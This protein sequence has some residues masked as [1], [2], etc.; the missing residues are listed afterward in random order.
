MDKLF[1]DTNIFESKGFNFDK[2]NILIKVLTN[3]IKANK[4]KYYNLSVIDN[5]IISH[6]K[7]KSGD[8]EKL[9][10]KQYKWIEKY[11]D[12]K[13]IHDNCFKNLIDYKKF[14]EDI[15]AVN[16]DVSKINAEKIFKKYFDIK[17]PFEVKEDKRKEFPDAFISEY[18][19]DLSKAE[20]DRVYFVSKDNG[21]KKS[22][23]ESITKYDSIEKFLIAINGI[24]PEDFLNI[25]N[26]IK[27]NLDEIGLRL[28]ENGDFKNIDL[29]EEIIE[30]ELIKLS[31]EF[32][33]EILDVNENEIYVSC[34]F[35]KLIISGDFRCLDYENSYWPNDEEYYVYTEYYGTNEIQ[36]DDYEMNLKIKKHNEDYIIEYDN[37]YPIEINFEKIK[38]YATEHF[39]PYDDY[40]GEDS[41]AQ[42]GG[43]R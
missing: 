43:S 16:C 42:D 8:E 15:G 23:D 29:E 12:E 26:Y 27:S 9:L 14:K 2:R 10:K 5:E 39:S 36:Y 28:L 40:D 22:L 24:P 20:S 18:I 37:I 17:F 7:K 19:N 41:W 30:P 1:I 6:I 25:K 35:D 31:D 32:N 13:T 11:M 38:E 33:F 4:Y 21:L 34:I 3:N